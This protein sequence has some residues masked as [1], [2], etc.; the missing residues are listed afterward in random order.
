MRLF[1]FLALGSVA[2]AQSDSSLQQGRA[3]FRSNCAFCH[4]MTATGGRGPNLVSTSLSHGDNDDSIKRVI[5][6]GV[7]GTTM[8]AFAEFT[9]EE[10]SNLVEYL[11]SLQNGSVRQERVPGDSAMGKQIYDKNGCANCHRVR[12]QGSI[13]GPDL[14]RIGAAR[15][16]EYIRESIANPSAD[17]PEAYQ[18]V[19]VVTKD[20]K[21]LTG[22]RINEDTFTVQ[23]LGN[24]Q[25][26]LMFDKS[27]LHGVTNQSKS[28]MPAY[29]LSES[30][31][32]NLV[33]YLASLRGGTVQ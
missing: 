26:Y 30:E 6:I 28:L 12:G 1:L 4:G 25:K 19:T 17:I 9:E 11:R 32:R 15:S 13:Y 21:S 20:G 22:R 14:S 8:P 27:E 2:V 18:G 5:R 33:A 3:L 16:I 31:L 10:V 7:P 23:L 29:K 24:E